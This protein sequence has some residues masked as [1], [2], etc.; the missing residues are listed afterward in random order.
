MIDTPE[1]FSPEFREYTDVIDNYIA[2]SCFDE[3]R[4]H[5]H[6]GSRAWTVLDD[7]TKIPRQTVLLSARNSPVSYSKEQMKFLE[8][9]M[10]AIKSNAP[11]PKLPT[12]EELGMFDLPRTIKIGLVM[13]SSKRQYKSENEQKSLKV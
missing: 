12:A 11:R 2:T 8:K 6:D 3:A 5:A 9:V 13:K 10:L 1:V 4:I 7:G